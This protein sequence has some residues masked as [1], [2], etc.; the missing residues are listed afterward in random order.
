MIRDY[1]KQLVAM[2]LTEAAKRYCARTK[3]TIVCVM[4]GKT[5][6]L[7]HYELRRA[8]AASGTVRFN[9]KG[10]TASLG[11]PLSVLGLRAG[12]SSWRKWLRLIHEARLVATSGPA[13]FCLV[14]EI[15]YDAPDQV[16]RLA[17]WLR[18]ALLLVT[19]EPTGD[20]ERAAIRAFAQASPS[21]RQITAG[22]ILVSDVTETSDGTHYLLSDRADRVERRVPR[23][24][25]NQVYADALVF[26]ALRAIG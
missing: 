9:T 13:V 17:S 20:Q 7:A 15:G 21:T 4:G 23:F 6:S 8:L 5:R 10:Y 25:M 2:T 3:P 11:V 22:N 26:S 14:L 12:F 16:A 24:G 1:A 19:D 18:P